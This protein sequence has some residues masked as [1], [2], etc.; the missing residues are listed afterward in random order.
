MVDQPD[1]RDVHPAP[2]EAHLSLVG[3]FRHRVRKGWQRRLD[4]PAEPAVPHPR[5]RQ[6]R[7]PHRRRRQGSGHATVAGHR[8]QCRRPP[9]RELRPG[10]H[11]AVHAR[12]RQLQRDR[13]AAG[14]PLLHRLVVRPSERELHAA[15]PPPRL[16]TEDGAR[17]DRGLR[18]RRP[19]SHR[20]HGPG[21]PPLHRRQ[22]LEPP[23]VPGQSLRRRCRPVGPRLQQG[24]GHHQPAAGH[25]PASGVH[26]A[27]GRAPDWSSNRWSTSWVPPA[28]S[29]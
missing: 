22:A 26:R 19:G 17:P 13:R 20:D 14:G 4:V 8:H 9:Q 28:P 24:S 25:F 12:H 11:G 7:D 15:G 16:R 18:R 23:G 21:I 1:D 29:G 27:D 5:R 3:P 6:L 10:A 2:R